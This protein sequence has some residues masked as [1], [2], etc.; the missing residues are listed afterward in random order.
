MSG[1]HQPDPPGLIHDDLRLLPPW[2]GSSL[3]QDFSHSG[4]VLP[5]TVVAERRFRLR[6]FTWSIHKIEL[7]HRSGVLGSVT[8]RPGHRV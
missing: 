6:T 4:Y 8:A 1:V 7:I 5:F 2:R 3:F